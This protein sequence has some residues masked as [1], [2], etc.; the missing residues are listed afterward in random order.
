MRGGRRVRSS[1]LR[2]YSIPSILPYFAS[3]TGTV[4]AS[5]DLPVAS[6]RPESPPFC[7]PVLT[8]STSPPSAPTSLPP[9]SPA[10][11]RPPPD[12][13]QI[14]LGGGSPSAH[15]DRDKLGLRC[16]G[17][18]FACLGTFT[19]GVFVHCD[20]WLCLPQDFSSLR[21][22]C[23]FS[24]HELP[25]DEIRVSHKFPCRA[26]AARRF[27]LLREGGG[28]GTRDRPL[29]GRPTAA[30]TQATLELVRSIAPYQ[31]KTTL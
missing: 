23:F 8:P 13:D 3:S 15:L 22:P 4:L 21:L 30:P 31:S 6:P 11:S 29:I 9:R 12:R 14:G 16:T 25:G 17:I 24:F 5:V 2:S 28:P 19:A 26:G 10:T 27:C 1:R 20:H 18:W 7:P